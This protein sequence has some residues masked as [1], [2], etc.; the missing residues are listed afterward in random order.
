MTKSIKILYLLLFVSISS[1]SSDVDFD[2]LLKHIEKKSD[3][4]SKTK[5][6]NGGI[7]FIYTR[8][9]L[10]RMQVTTLKDILK[11]T[12][13]FGYDENRFSLPD[14]MGFDTFHPFNSSSMR[15]FIDNQE[16]TTSLYG[17][18]LIVLGDIDLGF[19]D[20]IEV[21]SQNP[22]YEFSTEPT[23]ILIKLYSKKA[24][25][26]EGG[27]IKFSVTNYEGGDATIYH[28]KE[29]NEWSYFNYISNTNNK[30]KEFNDL[31]RDKKANHLFSSW[32]TKDQSIIIQAIEQKTDSFKNYS[33]DNTPQNTSLDIDFVHLGYDKKLNDLFLAI[34]YDYMYTDTQF[35]DDMDDSFLPVINQLDA[36]TKAEVFTA[37]VKHYLNSSKNRFISGLKY[38][39]KTF[40]YD[41]LFVND[42]D[43]PRTGH[44]IQ[45]VVTAFIENQYSLYLNSIITTGFQYSKFKNNNSVQQDDLFMFRLGHTYTNNNWIIKTVASRTKTSLDP[46]LINSKYYMVD[47][48]R[49]YQPQRLDALLENIIYQKNSDKFEL[50]LSKL[51]INNYL[52]PDQS[53]LLDNF[54]KKVTTY[55]TNFMW[56]KDYNRYDKLFLSLAYIKTDNL[57]QKEGLKQYSSVIRS[58]NSY[59]KLDFFN[60][61]L[62][63]K[64]NILN[65]D[66]YDYS[67]GVKYHYTKDLIFGLKGENILNKAKESTYTNVNPS[68]PTQILE[69]LEVSPID[70]KFLVS[71]EYLF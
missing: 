45:K 5:L 13:P 31:S 16:I 32:Y 69:P 33:L 57:P 50:I 8:D 49:Y 55:G 17:S 58:L 56:T 18:G 24:Q 62:Y 30:R 53:G 26:D 4:S 70:R 65:K 1:F 63:Y 44:T 37:E 7:S 42:L 46:F 67:L 40:N 71:L 51:T 12:Q 52:L 66:F 54:D 41:K 35:S 43:I 15:I 38:R 22:S 23:F 27:K 9:D 29:F 39:Y 21:Y 25:K 34:T 3:L 47:E 59:K 20:H 64:D 19:V 60:E 28:A 11:S 14:P 2:T 48:N 6:E 68:D 36:L 61:I 10:E